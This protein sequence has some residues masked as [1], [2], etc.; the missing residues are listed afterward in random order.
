MKCQN[1]G[2]E[3][4]EGAKFCKRC[5]STQIAKPIQTTQAQ[6]IHPSPSREKKQTPIVAA[7]IDLS[8]FVVALAVALVI[9]LSKR[10]SPMQPDSSN[11]GNETIVTTLP[12]VTDPTSGQPAVLTTEQQPQTAFT[13]ASDDPGNE[14]YNI[15]LQLDVSHRDP[16]I[17][18]YYD[19]IFAMKNLAPG[20]G[21]RGHE[22][23]DSAMY[24]GSFHVGDSQ[25]YWAHD[26]YD[27]Y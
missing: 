6:V 26:Y 16:G 18:D 23:P 22:I 20:V 3:L 10:A 12:T 15:A 19:D 21:R 9:V 1:C 8:V 25:T 2:V 4:P 13:D 7:A 17:E 14:E 5:G 27:T 24:P 11:T